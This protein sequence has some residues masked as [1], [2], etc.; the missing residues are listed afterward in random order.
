MGLFRR[1]HYLK[2]A[3]IC[4]VWEFG[5][6][7]GHILPHLEIFKKLK[8][9]GHELV[10]VVKEPD[11]V[12]RY[13]GNENL[14]CLQ[15]PVVKK[16]LNR[17]IKNPI[18][19]SQIL[20]NLGFYSPEIVYT[21]ISLW[22]NY[23]TLIDPDIVIFDFS[24]FALIA[25]QKFS[26]KK[27]IINEGYLVPPDLTPLPSVIEES[28]ENNKLQ[29]LED[30]ILSYINKACEM[31]KLPKLNRI[32]QIF[33][34]PD[35]LRF[36]KTL[37]EFDPYVKYR[38]NPN[39]I[40]FQPPE[41]EEKLYSILSKYRCFGYLKPHKNISAI[42]NLLKS[43]NIK[44]LIVID[45]VKETIIDESIVITNKLVNIRNIANSLE[46]AILN[47][48]IN[49]VIDFLMLGIPVFNLPLTVNQFLISESVSFH[50]LGA[51]ANIN[52]NKQIQKEFE[53]FLKNLVFYTDKVREFKD[54]NQ[55]YIKKAE[56]VINEL[57][58]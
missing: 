34:L 43:Y 11:K 47:G 21:H 33:Y 19:F 55:K 17:H 57:L 12:H 49:S 36:L 4:F 50:K 14:I 13:L 16:D 29:E 1:C 9:M 48:N 18:N 26:F 42:V 15:C 41:I 7:L 25:S 45:G 56:Y 52:N 23:F 2:M 6:G 54:K 24:P 10:F 53:L 20:Y 51:W 30:K 58:R 32:S 31:A 38:E 5:A 44:S 46:F 35:T 27:V 3:K 39:Y 8:Q 28:P 22:K 37:P 40:L